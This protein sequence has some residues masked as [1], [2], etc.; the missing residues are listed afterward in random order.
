MINRSK[1][2]GNNFTYFNEL[3][4]INY[5]VRIVVIV[6]RYNKLSFCLLRCVPIYT[7]GSKIEEILILR[8]FIVIKHNPEK[9]AGARLPLLL[10]Y[11]VHNWYFLSLSLKKNKNKLESRAK[12]CYLNI[13]EENGRSGQ[14]T[15]P[16]C[17]CLCKL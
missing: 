6:H 16:K 7:P 5:A 10:S 12:P 13:S 17:Y 2:V 11:T 3:I 8:N 14:F 15:I 1:C 9:P 4:I